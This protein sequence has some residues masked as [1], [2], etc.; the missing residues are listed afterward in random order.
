MDK[1]EA[2]GLPAE[3]P[4]R[5]YGGSGFLGLLAGA[6]SRP[7]ESH[8]RCSFAGRGAAEQVAR[9]RLR[10]KTKTVCPGPVDTQRFRRLT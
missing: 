10:C 1:T 3:P 9:V 5:L 2:Q 8:L 6:Y 7:P 4:W